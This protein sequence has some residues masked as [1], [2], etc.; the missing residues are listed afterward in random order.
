M[1]VCPQCGSVAIRQIEDQKRECSR[2]HYTGFRSSFTT[3]AYDP[4][5]YDGRPRDCGRVLPII[6][7]PNDYL[8][9]SE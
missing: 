1:L 6:D 5:N 2:C 7:D 8:E 9:A 4:F 3:R